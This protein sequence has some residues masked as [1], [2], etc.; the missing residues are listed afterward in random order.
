MLT[1]LIRPTIYFTYT[2][3][4]F[5]PIFEKTAIWATYDMMKNKFTW[6]YGTDTPVSNS[7]EI[8]LVSCFTIFRRTHQDS[9]DPLTLLLSILCEERV[10]LQR[11]HDGPRSESCRRAC[12]SNGLTAILTWFCNCSHNNN[13]NIRIVSICSLGMWTVNFH[14]VSLTRSELNASRTTALHSRSTEYSYSQNPRRPGTGCRT[15]TVR[16]HDIALRSLE[17]IY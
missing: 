14:H 3:P 17:T 4:I 6:I 1:I 11:C 13:Q 5:Y 12:L 2:L 15:W 7:I 9:H 16:P 10:E 8:Q